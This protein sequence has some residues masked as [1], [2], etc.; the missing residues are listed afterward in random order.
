MFLPIGSFGAAVCIL[1]AAL[2]LKR[3]LKAH[4]TTCFSGLYAI[5]QQNRAARFHIS[6]LNSSTKQLAG[7]EP[8]SYQPFAPGKAGPAL[9]RPRRLTAFLLLTATTEGSSPSNALLRLTHS[10]GSSTLLPAH[11]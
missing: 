7:E 6:A 10:S 8:Y 11:A 4:F 2:F 3:K 5:L 9:P 1:S